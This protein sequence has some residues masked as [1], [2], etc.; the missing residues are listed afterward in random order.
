VALNAQPITA[1]NTT[2]LF[3]YVTNASGFETG[4]AIAN[5]TTDNLK[6]LPVPGSQATPTNGTCTLNFYG[7]QVQPA[8]KTFPP[9]G[10]LG[11]WSTTITGQNPIYADTLSD[12]SGAT[13]FTGYAIAS[14]NFLEAHGFAFITDTTGAF[15]GAMGYLGVVLPN[16]RNEQ[17]DGTVAHL[18][19]Q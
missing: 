2:L 19:E 4:I 3:P 18:T 9:T 16:G 13:N 7:N 12:L 15:T 1:C 11:A 17:L 6:L 8:S 14:C 5:T 10:S